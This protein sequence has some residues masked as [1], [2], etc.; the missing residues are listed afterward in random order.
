METKFWDVNAVDEDFAIR[1]LNDTEQAEGQ[2]RF[3]RTGSPHDAD[4]LKK[5]ILFYP[6]SASTL[7]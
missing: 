2:R 5:T 1:S 4:L 3:T 6:K 7:G